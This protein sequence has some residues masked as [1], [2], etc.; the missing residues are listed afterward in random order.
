MPKAFDLF[1]LWVIPA[2]ASS[3]LNQCCKK[4]MTKDS[5]TY[6]PTAHVDPTR[7]PAVETDFHISLD[8]IRVLV[9]D[10]ET[11]T[12]R[13]LFDTLHLHGATI[14]LAES[15]DE[16]L[17]ILKY[18]KFDVILSDL[19]M[20]GMDGLDFMRAVRE[21]GIL[22]PSIALSGYTG[23]GPQQEALQAG[24]QMHLDKPVES[25]LLA[26]AVADLA[27]QNRK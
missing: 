10:D 7:P 5:R 18:E 23:V 26:A 3:W 22:T 1:T 13:L 12:R 25:P 17:R 6:K 9:V 16:A 24:F 2:P 21:R 27:E 20:D 19:G 4:H 11:D 8:G 15:G 14:T